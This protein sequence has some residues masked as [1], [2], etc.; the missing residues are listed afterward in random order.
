MPSVKDVD[1]T[2]GQPDI[3]QPE[4][5]QAELEVVDAWWRAANYLTVGQIYLQSNPLLPRAA[6]PR[7]HQAPAARSL[8]HLARV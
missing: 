1:R 2:V 8:G 4:I 3:G 7:P 5:E 6:R